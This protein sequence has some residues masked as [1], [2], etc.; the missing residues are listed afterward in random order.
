[1]PASAY[2]L[3]VMFSVIALLCGIA[4]TWI[5]GPRRLAAVVIPAL[6][7]FLALYWVGHRSGLELGPTVEI[8]GFR[9]AIVQDVIAGALGALVAAVCQRWVLGRRRSRRDARSQVP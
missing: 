8:L 2:G 4:A 7:A 6:V 1:M 5:V 9:V 3:V